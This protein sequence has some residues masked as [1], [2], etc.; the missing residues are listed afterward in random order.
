MANIA[1]LSISL[2]AKTRDFTKGMQRARKT[3]KGFVGGVASL[4]NK[5]RNM[6]LF[7]AAGV[8]AL[9][10]FI[11]KQM[12]ALDVLGKTADKLGVTTEALAGLH[13]AAELSGLTIEQFNMAAQ[14]MTRRVAEAA[15]GM[16]EAKQAIKTLGINAKSLVKLP[17]EQKLYVIADALKGVQN[18]AERIR[19]AFKLFDSEG[20]NMIHVLKQGSAGMR[21]M[22]REAK[23]MGLAFSRLD[24]ETVTIAKDALT[25]IK[26]ALKGIGY[27]LA[28]K[29]APY[30]KYVADKF[31]DWMKGGEGQANL[32]TRA[33]NWLKDTMRSISI[34]AIRFAGVF[35]EQFGKILRAAG[36]FVNFFEDIFF[37]LILAWNEAMGKGKPETKI[38]FFKPRVMSDAIDKWARDFYLKGRIIQLKAETIADGIATP[39]KS[40]ERRLREQAKT[41]LQ[42]YQPWITSLDEVKKA[43]EKTEQQLKGTEQQLKGG[44]F[45]QFTRGTL[46]R[47]L[48]PGVESGISSANKMQS[49]KDPQLQ[50]T[51][52]LLDRIYRNTRT[53][54]AVAG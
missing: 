52:V 29:V 15:G 13:Y 34:Q 3:V 35:F 11:K 19:L 2:T 50:T 49:V 42:G 12:D 5:L 33:L 14:R 44:E 41:A 17:L 7:A 54:V 4:A 45:M 8:S 48:I 16:G 51:N 23:D 21:E 1:G 53:P 36:R 39:F 28:V 32:I 20:V 46:G 18:P 43:A 10:Y 22:I 47:A 26:F 24:I 27:T 37:K 9:A 25:K 38:T 6:T 30:V 31:T 40:L